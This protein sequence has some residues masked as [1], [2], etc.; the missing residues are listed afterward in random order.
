MSFYR[1][2]FRLGLAKVEYGSLQ[3][4]ED[5]SGGVHYTLTGTKPGYTAEICIR[6]AYFYRHCVLYGEVGFGEAYVEGTWDADD[7]NVALRWFAQ[8]ARFLPGFSG[9][10][11]TQWFMNILGF[12]H[13]IKHFLRPNTRKISRRNIAE[14]YDIG[15]SLYELMLG[16]SMAYSCGVFANPKES[17]DKAQERKFALI[18]DKLQLK[19]TDHLLEIGSGW[20]GF[21]IYAAKHFGC[22][23]T[24]V[25]ISEQQYNYAK[26][27]I[28]AAKLDSRIDLQLQDYRLLTGKF[29]KIVS[30]EM[31][32]AIGFNYFD[33]YFKK[34][35]DL[36][37]DD[38]LM[39]LQYI[40][41]PESRFEQ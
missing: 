17:L 40:T 4:T 28:H 41:F 37:T 9:S 31:A 25:T 12:Y 39:L 19:K 35:A 3:V 34:C 23:I 26:L 33:T 24:T 36:L 14:H 2:L 8:N 32:E 15:N 5:F 20:G 7:L 29:D 22:K 13:R 27:K 21:A 1:R 38:G 6:D 30:I 10:G 18:C 16:R 11:A